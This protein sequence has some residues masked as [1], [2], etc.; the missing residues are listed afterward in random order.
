[1]VCKLPLELRL[2]C[3]VGLLVL[4]MDDWKDFSWVSGRCEGRGVV[5]VT[6]HVTVFAHNKYMSNQPT[7]LILSLYS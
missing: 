6:R 7:D 4:V 1:M 3:F 5:Q 2:L